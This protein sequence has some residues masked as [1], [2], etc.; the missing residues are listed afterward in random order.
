MKALYIPAIPLSVGKAIYRAT[1]LRVT[2]YVNLSSHV[3]HLESRK[4]FTV[5]DSAEACP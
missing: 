1:A 4:T 2:I 5:A 3:K